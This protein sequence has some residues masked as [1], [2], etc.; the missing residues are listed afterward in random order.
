MVVALIAVA[1][2]SAGMV[3]GVLGLL[4]ALI[5]GVLFAVGAVITIFFPYI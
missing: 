1:G 3:L 5:G 4:Y 2:L